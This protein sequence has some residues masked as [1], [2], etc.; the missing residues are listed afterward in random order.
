MEVIVRNVIRNI[1]YHGKEFGWD[2][3]KI[4]NF[5][6]AQS[7]EIAIGVV[8]NDSKEEGAGDQGIMFGY[9]CTE[10]EH[11]MPA[12][13]FY[14]N[15]LIK[16]IIE[17]SAVE[18][19]ANL[20]P[21]GKTQITLEYGK[22]RKPKRATAIVISIQHSKDLSQKD[23]ENIVKPIAIATLPLGW[24]DEQT[25]FYINPTGSFI[26]GGPTADTGLTGRKIIVDT[27]GGYAP[28]GGGAFS[29]K[30]PSKV[31]RSAAYAVRYL[32]K[33]L[34]SAGIADKCL[35]QVSYAIGVAQPLSIFVN[36][37]GTA[38][39]TYDEIIN[40]IHKIL[41]LSPRGIRNHLQLDKPIYQPSA[42][43]GHFGREETTEGHFSWERT[44]LVKDIQKLL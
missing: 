10:T 29:G 41:D 2:T 31:D 22:D 3:V 30:D 19:A 35:L 38:K 43:Y 15:Q 5:I 11:L 4:T 34:V 44:D 13:I 32:A 9:A 24:I 1:G 16:A 33:N 6:H 14:A 27:Y 39:A 42:T 26:L 21:D 36:T 17:K 12:A 23:V 37:F 8:G 25:K 28:H 20:G 7:P 40:N 18:G